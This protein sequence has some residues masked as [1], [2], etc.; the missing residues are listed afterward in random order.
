MNKEES[1]VLEIQFYDSDDT[2]TTSEDEDETETETVE[3]C[4]KEQR[5]EQ[6]HRKPRLAWMEENHHHYQHKTSYEFVPKVPL[7]EKCFW[8][9]SETVYDSET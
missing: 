2:T 9:M 6:Q 4:V 7:N 1:K 3:P 5:L 8:D